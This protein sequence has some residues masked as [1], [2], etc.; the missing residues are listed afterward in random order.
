MENRDIPIKI[1]ISG[2]LQSISL[3][4]KLVV[5]LVL[6]RCFCLWAL[7][8]EFKLY[9]TC[10]QNSPFLWS[11][12][13]EYK[14]AFCCPP[15]MGLRAPSRTEAM[16]A[17][18]AGLGVWHLDACWSIPG[19]GV[20]PVDRRGRKRFSALHLASHF[21]KW[22]H[23]KREKKGGN[24]ILPLSFSLTCS[25][26]LSHFLSFLIYHR[27]LIVVLFSWQDFKWGCWLHV[28]ETML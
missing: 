23:G 21:Q 6:K 19:P 4:V 17:V 18:S 20:P 10:Q 26:C 14:S 28:C 11:G 2:N 5:K 3:K 25:F 9:S 22:C 24:F 15:V 1:H 27:S 13:C 7:L 8:S 16:P 12:F